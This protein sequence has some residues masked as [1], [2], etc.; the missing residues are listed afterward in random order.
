[1]IK[2]ARRIVKKLRQN[3]H[4][5]LFAGGWVRDFLLN[6]Q[7]KD[8]DIATSAHPKEVL[9]LF[10]HSTAVGAQF[11]VVPVRMY[12]HAYEVA[13]FRSDAAYYDGRH[14]SSV[15]FSGPRQDAR[16]RD[17]TINGLFYDP[18][19]ER[20][21]DYVKGRSDLKNRR[22]RAIGDPG[23][24][25]N[26][27]KL[28][29]LRA[30]RF[31]CN[32]NFS[33]TAETWDAIQKLAP[34]IL[35]VSGERIRDELTTILIGPAPGSGLKML[36]ESG[37]LPHILPEVEA[38][39]GRLPFPGS[40]SDMLEGTGIALSLLRHASVELAFGTLLH[41]IGAQAGPSGEGAVFSDENAGLGGKT[42]EK[43]CRRLRMPGSWIERV[44]DLVRTQ[45]LLYEVREMRGS[46]LKRLLRK[47]NFSDHLELHRVHA[48]SS[49]KA[50]DCYD[51][52]RRKIREYADQLHAPPLITGEDLI[53]LG[54]KPGPL[55]KK[56][57]RTV[58]DLQ[59]DGVLRT[60]KD[61]IRHVRRLFP[62]SKLKIEN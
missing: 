1:M 30:I 33:I 41:Y 54:H 62:L 14:P 12:G 16:R 4:E 11:G 51:F 8:I 59:L 18:E 34:G 9:R 48:R 31:A 26:E 56:I 10:P 28:R 3:G 46:T 60:K 44:S 37:L 42:A 24:R 13:T 58:E 15:T 5:A 47:P 27:D 6:R 25:F 20:L 21:I 49:G 32:L 40:S 36:H 7:P 45:P 17:F 29:M 2:A 22:I 53:S 57:L 23:E 52:C 43:I 55:F 38:M 39:H 61:A 50:L 19:S 35:Q